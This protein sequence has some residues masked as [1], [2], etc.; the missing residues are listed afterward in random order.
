MRQLTRR[1]TSLLELL[2]VLTMLGITGTITVTLVGAAGR[3]ARRTTA[4]LF[5]ERTTHSLSALLRHDVRGSLTTDFTVTSPTSV[6][7]DRPLGEAPVCAAGGGVLTL[8]R[9]AWTGDRDPVPGRDRARVLGTPRAG[10][11]TTT[12]IL[13][14]AGGNC[15]DGAP[16]WR[17][18]VGSAVPG[19]SHARIVEPNRLAAYAG[20]GG[21]WLGLA[22]P[23]DP[24]QPF[25]GPLAVNG[26]ALSWSGGALTAA[27]T[28]LGGAPRMLAF[29]LVPP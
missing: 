4:L 16:A 28:P 13:D 11:W 23:G 9:S 27:V 1:G 22:G 15:P 6:D 18:A 17:L 10:L 7:L 14:L 5:A 12:P 3:G 19:A 26:L 29:P 2:T 24:I 25:A 21:R 20:A 8:R